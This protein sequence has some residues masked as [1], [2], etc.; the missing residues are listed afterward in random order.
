M[1]AIIRTKMR[2]HPRPR[3]TMASAV[4]IEAVCAHGIG[5]TVLAAQE[6]R[7]ARRGIS[8]MDA[9]HMDRGVVEHRWSG[10]GGEV[11]GRPWRVYRAALVLSQTQVARRGQPDEGCGWRREIRGREQSGRCIRWPVWALECMWERGEAERGCSG[12]RAAGSVVWQQQQQMGKLGRGGDNGSEQL[13]GPS[14]RQAADWVGK[15][16]ARDH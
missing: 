11:M 6:L 10:R 5:S 4:P 3:A 13:G 14:G 12:Q 15:A 8:T 16:G 9:G 1:L 7:G 2:M